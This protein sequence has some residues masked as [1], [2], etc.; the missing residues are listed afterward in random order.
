M[1]AAGNKALM[2]AGQA[3]ISVFSGRSTRLSQP[4]NRPR[5]ASG[6]GICVHHFERR[7]T[8]Q[9]EN[10]YGCCNAT[11]SHCIDLLRYCQS[12]RHR[13]GSRRTDTLVQIIAST[14]IQPRLSG[15]F[16]SCIDATRT[17]VRRP[18]TRRC[19]CIIV[20]PRLIRP[21]SRQAVN[22][23]AASRKTARDQSCA[24]VQY[25]SDRLLRQSHTGRSTARSSEPVRG[26]EDR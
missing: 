25:R 19:E 14:R 6:H 8:D 17:P 26:T 5:G 10:F 1:V 15:F 21:P 22:A 24:R 13:A 23:G 20:T 2:R 16:L 11:V 12:R 7:R 4:D 9:K 18:E 3:E